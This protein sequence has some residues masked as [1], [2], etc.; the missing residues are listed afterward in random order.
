M[1]T[2]D[3]YG[4]KM[5]LFDND[6]PEEFLLFVRN[7]N[8]TLAASGTLEAGAKYQYLCNL[9][10]GEALRQFDSLSADVD[11]SET[12]NVDYIITGLAQYF[13]P[14]NSLS[15]Q[16]RAMRRGIKNRAA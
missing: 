11:F 12:L 10:R 6:E 5:S 7:F 13:P 3:L 16:K 14:V 4:F 1:P 8:M 9:V 15:K 2:L